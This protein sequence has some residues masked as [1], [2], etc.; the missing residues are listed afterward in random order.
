MLEGKNNILCSVSRDLNLGFLP[1]LDERFNHT[2]LVQKYITKNS[3][4]QS[5]PLTRVEAGSLG[6]LLCGMNVLQWETLIKDDIFST[7][8]TRHLS[9]LDCRLEE[10]VISHLN[11]RMMSEDVF[12]VP[13][14][15]STSD[16]LGMGW[17]MSLLTPHQLTLIPPHAMEGELLLD[18]SDSNI[19][20]NIF[21]VQVYL[22]LL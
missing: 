13:E 6:P 3:K 8:T 5:N 2:D 20:S 9:K 19:I 14:S 12:G 4:N 10:S 1:R 21:C 18:L 17:M 22:A 16:V 11:Q 7:L 15:W